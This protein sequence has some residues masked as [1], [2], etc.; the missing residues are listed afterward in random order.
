MY[1]IQL[2]QII[3]IIKVP[4]ENQNVLI[5]YQHTNWKNVKMLSWTIW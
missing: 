1:Y 5:Q 4:T 2:I 3:I